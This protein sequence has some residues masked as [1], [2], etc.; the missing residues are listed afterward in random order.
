MSTSHSAAGAPFAFIKQARPAPAWVLR[1]LLREGSVFTRIQPAF[2]LGA[3]RECR[4]NKPF[5]ICL[6]PELPYLTSS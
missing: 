6:I 4:E 1:N 2:N 5:S 3:M